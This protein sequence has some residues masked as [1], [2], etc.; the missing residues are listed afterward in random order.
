[1]AVTFQTGTRM[2]ANVATK[3]PDLSTLVALVDAAQ[4]PLYAILSGKGKD[5]ITKMGLSLGKKAATNVKIEWFGDEYTPYRDTVAT[6]YTNSA[7]GVVVDHGA[8]FMRGDIVLNETRGDLFRV[9]SV[10]SNTLTV[11]R[12][13][14]GISGV[15]GEVGDYLRIV[16][17]AFGEGSA[18]GDAISVKCDKMFNYQ[19]IFKTLVSASG[20]NLRS[21]D[22]TENDIIRQEKKKAIEHAIKI[23][24]ALWFGQKGTSTESATEGGKIVR[25]ME[26]VIG[27]ISTY[28]ASGYGTTLSETEWNAFLSDYAF[29]KGPKVKYMFAGT[30]VLAAVNTFAR[31]Q[32]R[33]VP[34]EKTWGIALSEYISPYGKMFLVHEPLFDGSVYKGYGVVLSPKDLL[35][36]PMK[37]TEYQRNIQTPG[38]DKLDNQFFTELSLQLDNEPHFAAITGVT[39]GYAAS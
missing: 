10:S 6:L 9:E 7:T 27:F 13:I 26:G 15:Q 1:M 22:Y 24:S 25:T 2:M 32:L 16:G 11:K 33:S 28:V 12:G 34:S 18:K 35:L 39:S 21:A 37:D 14:G 31:N 17:S 4:Y 20:D 3:K 8:Y 30:G 19:Q 29:K 23:E 38:D 36:R 5:P